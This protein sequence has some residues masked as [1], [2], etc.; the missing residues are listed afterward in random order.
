MVTILFALLKENSGLLAQIQSHSVSRFILL[1]IVIL[2]FRLLKIYN[3]ILESN[4]SYPNLIVLYLFFLLLTFHI[5][6]T[7]M[8]SAATSNAPKP[9]ANNTLSRNGSFF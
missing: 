3:K 6:V 2:F 4:S 5:Y 9:V 8:L 7:R 1:L